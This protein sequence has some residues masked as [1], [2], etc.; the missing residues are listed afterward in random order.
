MSCAVAQLVFAGGGQPSSVAPSQSSSHPFPQISVDTHATPQL[1]TQEV[2][3]PDASSPA[4]FIVA[5]G[6]ETHAW[7]ET[8]SLAAQR[9]A[10]HIV[11]GPD[12][13]SPAALVVP[14]AQAVQL[15]ARTSWSVAQ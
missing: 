1:E 4:S 8:C 7:L 9:I 11:S 12:A 3:G 2:S 5:L 6:H 15:C 14:G 13:S 10:S